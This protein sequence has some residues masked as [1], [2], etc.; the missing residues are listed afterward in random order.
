MSCNA[1]RSD[2]YTHRHFPESV[3][4]THAYRLQG[5]GIRDV[6]GR[7]ITSK[8]GPWRLPRSYVR[9]RR[10]YAGRTLLTRAELWYFLTESQLLRH[11]T[12]GDWRRSRSQHGTLRT[13]YRTGASK[14][15]RRAARPIRRCSW[16][17]A[18]SS[19]TLRPA[20][21]RLVNAG[22]F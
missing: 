10:W 3:C 16:T 15:C 2:T 8:C 5:R 21:P 17:E 7:E 18:C 12:T 14:R 11:S 9:T 22:V 20:S 19:S 13:I 1:T 4:V 6:E